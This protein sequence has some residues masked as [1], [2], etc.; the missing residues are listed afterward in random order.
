LSKFDCTIF[1]PVCLGASL[2]F[3]THFQVGRLRTISSLL[4]VPHH[5]R[6][7]EVRSYLFCQDEVVS[8]EGLQV[9]IPQPHHT[10]LQRLRLCGYLERGPW[11]GCKSGIP[12]RS[13]I[14][15]TNLFF[16][17]QYVSPVSQT[18]VQSSVLGVQQIEPT[19]QLLEGD[20]HLSVLCCS[21]F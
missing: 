5:P 20:L 2:G 8:S 21:R 6:L 16:S 3:K 9:Q 1:N 18:D 19:P 10:F 15:N 4:R 11:E 13:Y 14:W 17:H 7:K 12:Y